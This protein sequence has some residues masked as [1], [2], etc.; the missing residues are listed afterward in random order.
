MIQEPKK[1]RHGKVKLWCCRC[2]YGES[3]DKD[4]ADTKEAKERERDIFDRIEQHPLEQKFQDGFF[5]QDE[6]YDAI[7]NPSLKEDERFISYL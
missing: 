4:Y 5:N 3:T 7:N 1:C 2:R 6:Y